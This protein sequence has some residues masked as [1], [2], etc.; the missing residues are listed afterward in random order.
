[1]TARSAISDQRCT[2]VSSGSQYTQNA[3]SNWKYGSLSRNSS[4][5]RISSSDVQSPCGSASRR[6]I[7]TDIPSTA[8]SR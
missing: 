6:P 3:R 5:F 8:A 4:P 2:A 7:A 1:V